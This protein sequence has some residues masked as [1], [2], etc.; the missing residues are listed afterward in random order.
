[1]ENVRN[2]LML[3]SNIDQWAI[4][5]D[6]YSRSCF[7]ILCEPKKFSFD[8]DPNEKRKEWNDHCIMRIKWPLIM[9]C[10][11]TFII[12]SSWDIL[13]NELLSNNSHNY[14]IIDT[15]QSLCNWYMIMIWNGLVNPFQ[16]RNWIGNI[17][18][19]RMRSPDQ[20]GWRFPKTEGS[21]EKCPFV[22]SRDSISI[23]SPKD[24]ELIVPE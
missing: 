2:N 21:A 15:G 14:S 23:F 3:I 9:L 19:N 11:H 8:H 10:V 13:Y 17:N 12:W 7:Y 24:L 1:M 20:Q 18:P 4:E 16:L 5:K 22:L 6:S